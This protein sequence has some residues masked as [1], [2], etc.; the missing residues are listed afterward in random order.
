MINIKKTFVFLLGILVLFSLTSCDRKTYTAEEK[1]KILA[2]KAEEEKQAQAKI[3]Q[4]AELQKQKD[5]LRFT[6]LEDYKHYID[7]Y[8]EAELNVSKIPF[9]GESKDNLLEEAQ[10]LSLEELAIKLKAIYMRHPEDKW[11]SNQTGGENN[12]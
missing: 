2:Q 5:S 9:V 6:Y 10:K 7:K 3:A 11:L 4:E 12:G 1:E 8:G